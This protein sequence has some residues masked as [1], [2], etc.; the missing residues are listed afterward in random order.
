MLS[1][2]ASSSADRAD[3]FF[4]RIFGNDAVVAMV[5][6]SLTE[7][8]RWEERKR[9]LPAPVVVWLTLMLA[10]HR[11]LSI[12]NA[13]LKLQVAADERLSEAS[14]FKVTDEALCH[15]RA[16]LG[17][18][19]LMNLFGKTAEELRP[20]PSFA[21]LHA[22]VIDGTT[23]DIPDTKANEEHFG[24]PK[25]H[26]G[27]AAFPQ[28]KLVP[29][30]CASSRRIKQI[31][32]LGSLEHEIK[33]LHELLPHIPEGDVV[34]VDRGLA[35]YG[36]V[37]EC[38]RLGIHVVMRISAIYK[39]RIVKQIG[40]GDYLVEGKFSVPIP[41]A[42]QSGGRKNRDVT[43]KARMIV[44]WFDGDKQPVRLLT[45]LSPEQAS[46]RELAE[47]YHLRWEVE[48][49]IGELKT[50]L[51]AICHGKLHTTFRSKSPMLI[52]QEVFA[53]LATYNLVR[54]LMVQA[55]SANNLD[56]LKISFVGTLE[57]LKTTIPY[58]LL[59]QE[60]EE[61]NVKLRKLLDRIAAQKLTRFRRPRWYPR[62]VKQKMG[63]YHL[64]R[65]GDRGYLCDFKAQIRLGEA[66]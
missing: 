31:R 4:L 46:G 28:L 9:R 60:P 12:P 54:S 42:E 8:G 32:V 36:L 22:W 43:V 38:Q 23:C 35:S 26:R 18:E 5:H 6:A 39:P 45:T 27:M 63:S 20:Q 49:G 2:T 13:F 33:A 50:H 57:V 48:L 56:P 55:A 58:L 41:E 62:K 53:L 37:P 11:S 47:G 52:L 30:M 21:G 25:V 59:L 16:R 40:P 19:P 7:T 51:S 10:L 66:A 24:R 29:L 1:Q 65:A 44:F 64:K 34:F 61:W 3:D 14:T 15:A 17:F